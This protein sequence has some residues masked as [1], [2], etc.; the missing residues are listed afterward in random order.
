MTNLTPVRDNH[1]TGLSGPDGSWQRLRR[2]LSKRYASLDGSLD[3]ELKDFISKTLRDIL[4]GVKDAQCQLGGCQEGMVAP[5]YGQGYTQRDLH[6]AG[7][8]VV[9]SVEFEVSVKAH[10]EQGSI[11]QAKISVVN[12]G[13]ERSRKHEHAATLRFKI[14]LLL[15]VHKHTESCAQ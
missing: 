7:Q 11:G 5:E 4:H 13:G 9:Q 8:G 1:R 12:F 6:Q 15:P 3:I 14:P 10:A 2:M